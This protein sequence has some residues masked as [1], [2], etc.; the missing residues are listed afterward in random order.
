V[1]GENEMIFL[2]PENIL[3]NFLFLFLLSEFTEFFVVNIEIYPTMKLKEN[4]KKC[5]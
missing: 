1:Y 2:I 3:R 5:L 4:C